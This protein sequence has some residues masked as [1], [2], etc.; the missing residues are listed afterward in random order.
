MKLTR[1]INLQGIVFNIDEDAYQELKAYLEDIE[2]RLPTEETKDVMD[3][4]ESRIAELFQAALFDCKAQSVTIE[5]FRTIRTRIGEPNEFGSNKRPAIKKERISRQRIG[6]VLTIVFKA[7]LIII[8]IQLLFPV[9]ATVFG[10]LMAFFGLSIGGVAFVPALGFELM[11]GSTAWTWTLCIS[12]ILA[13][14][15]PLDVIIHWIVKFSRERKHPGWKFWIIMLLIWLLSIGGLAASAVKILEVNGADI[16]TLMSMEEPDE[17]DASYTTESRDVEPFHA[18]ELSGAIKAD[19]ELGKPQQIQVRFDKQGNIG[20]EVRDG[21]LYVLGE[22]KHEGKATIY[23]PEIDA[24]SL[25][26]ASK[27]EM[28]G[29]AD[30]LRLSVS[31]ASKVEAEELIVRNMH[32]N[33]SGAS[34]AEVNVTD[35]L[36]AQAA[37]ASKITY[38]GNPHVEQ[39]LAVGA[40]KIK[41]D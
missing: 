17:Q 27:V 28:K 39:I 7:I 4:V 34:K 24:L 9:L 14:G 6:R 18:I 22:G 29:K 5:M 15:L 38:K 25:T 32:L 3:D 30:N 8:A 1:N 10:L 21:V 20:T 2:S 31:G 12:I 37:G 19:V 26:G 36:W 13:T 35:S 41:R 33:V 40:S 11:G 16:S 23:V